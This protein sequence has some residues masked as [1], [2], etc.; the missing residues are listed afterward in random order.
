MCSSNL[1]ICKQTNIAYLILTY[2]LFL[3]DLMINITHPLDNKTI[4]TIGCLKNLSG[5]PWYLC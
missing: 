2:S 5:T 1:N 3:C 4:W